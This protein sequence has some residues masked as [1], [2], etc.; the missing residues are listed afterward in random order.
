MRVDTIAVA[1]HDATGRVTRVGPEYPS[2][3][4]TVDEIQRFSSPTSIAA[5]EDTPGVFTLAMG[6]GA[7]PNTFASVGFH[8]GAI[9]RLLQAASRVGRAVF[10]GRSPANHVAT[11]S[12]AAGYQG[13]RDPFP[14]VVEPHSRRDGP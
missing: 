12:F 6:G 3:Q 11:P 7:G 14:N 9:K 8:H 1:A 2:H 10:G 4:N 13:Q 5:R